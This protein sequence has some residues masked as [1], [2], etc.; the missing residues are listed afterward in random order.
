M[1]EAL[2]DKQLNDMV[3]REFAGIDGELSKVW[4]DY[5]GGWQAGTRFAYLR[6]T[7]PRGVTA[8]ASRRAKRLSRQLRAITGIRFVV[9]MYLR[10]MTWEKTDEVTARIRH[11]GIAG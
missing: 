4:I 10:D 11:V 3:A 7:F 2:T 9:V 6:L 1:K 5:M 8:E